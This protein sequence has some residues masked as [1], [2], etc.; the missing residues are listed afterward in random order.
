MKRDV[1]ELCVHTVVFVGLLLFLMLMMKVVLCYFSLKTRDTA[2]LPAFD[3]DS[4]SPSRYPK[5]HRHTHRHSTYT[6]IWS[7]THSQSRSKYPPIQ[8]S[9]KPEQFTTKPKLNP[10]PLPCLSRRQPIC[11]TNRS[12]DKPLIP[13]ESLITY[14]IRPVTQATQ[15]KKNA[16]RSYFLSKRDHTGHVSS[17][18]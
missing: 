1:G 14:P 6:H 2:V 7:N 17:I 8:S 15:H 9:R 16:F 12:T 4:F 11:A 10:L 3:T 18:I 5:P 13:N